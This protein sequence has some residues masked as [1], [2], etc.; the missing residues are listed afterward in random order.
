[1][2]C[3]V[4]QVLHDATLLDMEALWVTAQRYIAADALG[5]RSELGGEVRVSNRSKT[6]STMSTAKT[7]Y[8]PLVK[9]W[10][11]LRCTVTRLPPVTVV[12]SPSQMVITEMRDLVLSIPGEKEIGDGLPT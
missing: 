7:P 8:R 11:R 10:P 12:D 3:Q 4:L 9:K 1:L 2:G 5:Q 6:F